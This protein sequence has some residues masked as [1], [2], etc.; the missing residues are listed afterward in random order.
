MNPILDNE[1]WLCE[2]RDNMNQY[3]FMFPLGCRIGKSYYRIADISNPDVFKDT[4]ITATNFKVIFGSIYNMFRTNSF[5]LNRIS[6]FTILKTIKSTDEKTMVDTLFFVFESDEVL[7]EETDAFEND[8]N[9]N[10]DLVFDYTKRIADK[11]KRR[12]VEAFYEAN[13]NI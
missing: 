3:E 10:Y 12:A 6:D 4:S 5:P 8:I 9:D 7:K 1:K 13:K 2:M 11:N